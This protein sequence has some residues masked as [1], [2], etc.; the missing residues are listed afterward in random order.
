M[1]RSMPPH[2]AF[3]DGG[4]TEASWYMRLGM[5]IN[6]DPPEYMLSIWPCSAAG[7]V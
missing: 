7:L 1:K 3:H 5:R 6:S 4:V 2:P